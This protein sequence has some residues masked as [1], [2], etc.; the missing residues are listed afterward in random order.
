MSVKRILFALLPVFFP[1]AGFGQ[2]DTLPVKNWSLEDC[3][4]YAREKNL[5]VQSAQV[6]LSSA[7]S[8][9]RQA[10]ANRLPGLSASVSQGLT[11]ARRDIQSGKS[12][13]A[14]SANAQ[15]SSSMILYGGGRLNNTLTQKKTDAQARALDVEHT[16]NSIEIRVTQAY[17]QILYAQ[18]AVGINRSTLETSAR[19]MELSGE[20]YR[21]GS[22]AL[23][24]YAQMQSQYASDQ[25]QLVVAE[26]TLSRS[27][28]DLKQLLELEAGY[29]FRVDFPTIDQE[30]VV[31]PIPSSVQVYN[32]ALESMPEV[33]SALLGVE[34]ARIGEQIARAASI[35]SLSLS[36][37]IGTGYAT[38][39]SDAFA[40]QLDRSLSENIGLS[41]SIPIFNNRQARTSKEKARL[42]SLSADIS[43]QNVRKDLLST[44][45]SLWQDAVS[46]QSRYQAAGEK[47]RAAETSYELVNEQFARGMKNTVE[48]LQ[49]KDNYLSAQT[50]SVQAKYQAV[51]S[52]KLLDFYRNKP[53]TL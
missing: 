16:Q 43:L 7:Q 29:D 1:L 20:L 28:L 50:E 18:E 48:L 37:G 13:Y 2:T 23:S 47:L 33:K 26:N 30:Q 27:I 3:I 34:S 5:D 25:Y 46:A 49:E 14:Y 35:P 42:Q 51:L 6:S 53:I 21:A 40:R 11:H 17:L 38:T 31:R 12:A 39:S 22:I 32:T 9:V 8:D 52:I 36:A 45:E 4:R 41:L 24:D 15:L 19:Q 44:I 10:A